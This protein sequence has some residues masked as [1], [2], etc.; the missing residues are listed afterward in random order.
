M[1]KKTVNKIAAGVQEVAA[2]A[3]GETVPAKTYVPPELD[4]RRLRRAQ[5]LT[6]EEFSARYGLP[7]AMI[8]DW[9]RGRRLPN[10]AARALLQIIKKDPKAAAQALRAK[11]RRHN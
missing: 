8:R 6:Q 9:E 10:S 3:R 5:G 7:V 11:L 2:I 4:V 1:S